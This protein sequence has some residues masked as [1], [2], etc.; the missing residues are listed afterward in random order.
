MMSEG[1]MELIVEVKQRPIV[2]RILARDDKVDFYGELSPEEFISYGELSRQLEFSSGIG[3]NDSGGWLL[4]NTDQKPLYVSKRTVRYGV[5]YDDLE[6]A[7]L[8]AGDRTVVIHGV[9][10]RVRLLTDEEWDRLIYPIHVD[11]PW[12]WEWEINYTDQDLGVASGE[13]RSSWVQGSGPYGPNHRFNRGHSS[14][15]HL[16]SNPSWFTHSDFG[17]RVVLEPIETMGTPEGTEV[18]EE[19]LEVHRRLLAH[20]R[21]LE[22]MLQSPSRGTTKFRVPKTHSEKVGLLEE[23]LKLKQQIVENTQRLV[24][25]RYELRELHSFMREYGIK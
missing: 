25:S 3:H 11:D 24:E 1:K 16:N 19:L 23:C 12:S 20:H 5:S 7:N 18:G 13:G 4:F 9:E 21:K 2:R 14:L 22:G 15:A 10:Y 8:V 6:A 17:W